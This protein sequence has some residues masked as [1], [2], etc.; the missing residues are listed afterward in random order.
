MQPGNR[1]AKWNGV[2]FA[3]GSGEDGDGRL[4]R[5]ALIAADAIHDAGTQADAGNL[6]VLRVDAGSLFVGE[7][8]G[9]V[10]RGHGL[11]IEYAV[12]GDRAGIGDALDAEF[13]R[14]FEDV[15]GADDVDLGPAT[16]SAL[17]NGTCSAARWM[18]A[19]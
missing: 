14:G 11:R 17:Q 8:V 16:G 7:F 12:R 3:G 10:K 15:D 9:T 1:A 2:R 18:I 6:P 4:R 13:A 19:F 5:H